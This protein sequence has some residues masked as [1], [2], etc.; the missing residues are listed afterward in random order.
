MRIRALAHNH[1]PSKM[2]QH[3][4]T[5]W[6]SSLCGFLY[7]NPYCTCLLVIAPF[8]LSSLLVTYGT[9]SHHVQLTS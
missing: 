6:C 3:C 2:G 8:I 5:G 9:P 4:M 7:D 1:D